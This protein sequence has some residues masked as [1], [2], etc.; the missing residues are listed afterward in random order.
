MSIA[1]DKFKRLKFRKKESKN[2]KYIEYIQN[3]EG[4]QAVISFDEVTKTIM[5]V[6]Y[7]KGAIFSRGLAITIEEL[8]AI[9]EKIKELEWKKI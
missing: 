7:P 5:A 3:Q 9:N 8:D 4:T 6:L 1:D 2:M